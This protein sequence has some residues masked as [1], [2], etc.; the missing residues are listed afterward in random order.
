MHT[1]TCIQVETVSKSQDCD[2]DVAGV[3]HFYSVGET[4]VISQRDR[5]G[6][7]DSGRLGGD[8]TIRPKVAR[9]GTPHREAALQE[10]VVCQVAW[11]PRLLE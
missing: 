3:L 6:R 8:N 2:A 10:G 7:A 1:S 11:L 4:K 9:K 5:I